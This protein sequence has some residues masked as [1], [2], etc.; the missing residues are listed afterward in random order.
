[1][2]PS[3]RSNMVKAF[4]STEDYVDFL[5]KLP[6]LEG[7]AFCLSF[8]PSSLFP[9]DSVQ[10]FFERVEITNKPNSISSQL[11]DYGKRFMRAVESGQ[12]EL[13]VD[14][15][16]LGNLCEK[17]IVHEAS[18]NFE[19]SFA[20]RVQVLKNLLKMIKAN[21]V[22]VI[23]GPVP[24]VFRL[25]SPSGVLLDVTKNTAEQRIQGLWIEDIEVFKAFQKEFT[26]LKST[27]TSYGQ[28]TALQAQITQAISCLKNGDQYHWQ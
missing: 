24:Y 2:F 17:G 27:A 1:M 8:L 22:F 5:T 16:A 28:G 26:R 25:H 9:K 23:E 11:W 4:E 19:V 20:V 7:E 10:I 18:P 14:K 12:A 6:I 13:C 3:H 21:K 15:M